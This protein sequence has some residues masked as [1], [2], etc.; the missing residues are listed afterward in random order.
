MTNAIT[1][2]TMNAT[3][4]YRLGAAV[5]LGAAAVL[6]FGVGALGVIGSGGRPDLMYLAVLAVGA[7]GALAARFRPR[8][9]AV[10]LSVTAVGMVVVAGIALLAGLQHNEGAS[11]GEI[12]RLSAGFAAMFGVSAWLFSRAVR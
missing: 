5:A 9:M 7:V 10:A 2:E 11:A 4:Y 3:T 8:G 1:E 6:L 12:L